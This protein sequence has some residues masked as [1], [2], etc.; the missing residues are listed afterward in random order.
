MKCSRV[1]VDQRYNISW[2]RT[3]AKLKTSLIFVNPQFIFSFSHCIIL[4]QT[5][6]WP[7][8]NESSKDCH[9]DRNESFTDFLR[10]FL[11]N[12]PRN[13]FCLPRFN[14][15]PPFFSSNKR[16]FFPNPSQH[17]ANYRKRKL[18]S[19]FFSFTTIIDTLVSNAFIT[20][21]EV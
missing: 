5:L 15:I 11:K 16:R 2:K 8:I 21:F 14:H 6:L 4:R 20:I 3:T 9:T 1:Y 10:Y 19:I 12:L 7:S 18:I 13:Y 17:F